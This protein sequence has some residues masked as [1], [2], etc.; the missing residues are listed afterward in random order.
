MLIQQANSGPSAAINR[1]LA[2]ADGDLVAVIDADDI[3]LPEKTRRQAERLRDDSSLGMVF[4]DMR[5]VDRDERTVRPSQPSL[6][7]CART[8]QPKH[9][10]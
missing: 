2:E 1:A 4:C 7:F 6:R 8:S 5:V 3:W 9:R 10:S